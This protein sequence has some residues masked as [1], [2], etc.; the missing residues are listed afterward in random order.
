MAKLMPVA[1]DH[2]KYSMKS[3]LACILKLAIFTYA[4]AS[5]CA[6]H[7]VRYMVMCYNCIGFAYNMWL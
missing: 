6:L 3:T 2:T 1:H 7:R 4:Y 5:Q